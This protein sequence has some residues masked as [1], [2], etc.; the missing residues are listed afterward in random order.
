MTAH[1]D[2]STAEA[3]QLLG[4]HPKTIKRWAA[5]GAVP[6]WQTPGGWW[7]FSRAELLA[8]REARKPEQVA[9]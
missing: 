2:L 7:K 6:A 3:A 4:V 1:S 8:W 5:E 9:S